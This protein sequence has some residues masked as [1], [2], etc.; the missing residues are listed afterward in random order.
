MH[1]NG[2]FHRST[3]SK[4]YKKNIETLEDSYADKILELRPVW[5]N[6]TCKSDNAEWG[7]WGLIAEEVAEVDPRLVFWKTENETTTLE[8]KLNPDTNQIE[9]TPVTVKTKLETPEAEGV[10]YDRIIPHL[11]NLIKRQNER[12]VNLEKEV[13]TLKG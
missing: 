3:S 11:L 8:D 13:A 1:T 9:Q 12:L 6:S 7:F 10:Q 2:Q 5:F 4:K